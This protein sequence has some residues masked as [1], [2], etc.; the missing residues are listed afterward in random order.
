MG[1]LT[2]I[3]ASAVPH[4]LSGSVLESEAQ[5]SP[6]PASSWNYTLIALL[7]CGHREQLHLHGSS[8]NFPRKNS[9]QRS[10]SHGNSLPGLYSSLGHPLKSRW[11]QPHPHS[12]FF[13]PPHFLPALL[14]ALHIIPGPLVL[15]LRHQEIW[16][17]NAGSRVLR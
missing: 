15:Y 7:V 3:I 10:H 14:G 1:S 2:P 12:I 9:L 17:W 11:K 4:L 6:H 13:Q 16:E 5:G 8:V